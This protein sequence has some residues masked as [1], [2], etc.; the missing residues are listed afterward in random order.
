MSYFLRNHIKTFRQS[1]FVRNVFAVATG[2]AAAQAI[3][4]AFMP[5]LTRLYGPEAFGA[6]AAFTAILN[7]ITPLAT[8]GYANAIVM[9]KTQEG[10]NAVARL[11]LVSAVIVSPVALIV[12]Y[13]FQEQLTSLAGLSSEPNLLYLIP[14]SLV[15]LALLSVANQAAIREGLFKAKSSS[16]VASTFI[17]NLGKLGV[18]YISATGITLIIFLIIS[19]L[20]NYT[21]LMARVPKVGAFDFRQWFGISGIRQAAF[22][23]KDFAIYR[24]PQ[25]ILNAASLGL[26]V[27]LLT[28]F[29]STSA[30]GQY[31]ITT[32]ILGAPVMLLGNSVLEVFFPKITTLVRDNPASAFH[33]LWKSTLLMSVIGLVPFSIIFLWG[34]LILPWVL[35]EAWG[36]AGEYSQWIALWMFSVLITRPAV[37]A[38]PVLKL[39]G[40]LLVYEIIITVLRIGS[41][42]LGATLGGDLMAVTLF[43]VV[44]IIG[45]LSLL[46]FVLK[47]CKGII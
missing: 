22:N 25:S 27:I 14:I 20:I 11:S 18:G 8:L 5:F 13:A 37:A 1:K 46:A 29:F 34:D 30:A 43:S 9:P 44:N 23:Y 33:M 10:A 47:K 16:Y 41:I 6:L 39:Q 7:I 3:S 12:I 42:S 45:Y 2:I 35:G 24:M 31:A 36:R 15:L 32:L 38:M 17:V 40:F 28:N 19:N 4:L 26:P 21:M